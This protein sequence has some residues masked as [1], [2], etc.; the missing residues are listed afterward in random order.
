MA[1]R[2]RGAERVREHL[3]HTVEQL[4]GIDR[5]GAQLAT[6]GKGQQALTDRAPRWPQK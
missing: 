3:T 4:G 5:L 2:D 6:T 1:D